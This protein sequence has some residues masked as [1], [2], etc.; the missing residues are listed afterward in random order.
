LY[1]LFNWLDICSFKRSWNI[2]TNMIFNFI[3]KFS[4]IP[5]PSTSNY[6]ELILFGL[7]YSFRRLSRRNVRFNLQYGHHFNVNLPNS[8]TGRIYKRRLVVYGNNDILQPWLQT[9]MLL[10]YP[11]SHTGKGL[12]LRSLPYNVKPGKE[13]KK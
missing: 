1:F 12:R 3:P 7:N 10:R 9:T 2:I 4:L 11:N 13:R 6:V 8:V 5:K